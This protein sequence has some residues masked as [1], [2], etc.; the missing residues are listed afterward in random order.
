MNWNDLNK[1]S[2]FVTKSLTRKTNE[3]LYK[4]KAPKN[5]SSVRDIELPIIVIEDL[6]NLKA[7]Q[8]QIY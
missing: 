3:K 4:I 6:N 2:I 8:E 7:K 1:T 5:Q